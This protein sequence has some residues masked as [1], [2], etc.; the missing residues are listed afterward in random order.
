MTAAS[1]FRV[2]G[3][4]LIAVALVLAFPGGCLSEPMYACVG[5]PLASKGSQLMALASIGGAGLICLA[6]ARRR[7]SQPRG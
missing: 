1:A 6:A 4:T 3:W 2:A 7:R 5:S